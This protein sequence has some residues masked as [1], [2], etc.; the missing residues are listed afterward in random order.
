MR[1]TAFFAW[2][3]AKVGIRSRGKILKTQLQ[4]S[5][6]KNCA[7]VGSAH[8]KR[9][10]VHVRN[11]SARHN[12]KSCQCCRSWKI[13]QNTPLVA[14]FGFDTAENATSEN[15]DIGIPVH[16]YLQ[17]PVPVYPTLRLAS[18]CTW[19]ICN[20]NIWSEWKRN[21]IWSDW[22][23]NNIWSEWKLTKSKHIG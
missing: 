7:N 10:K 20:N 18:C 16:W 15:R 17:P 9:G 8:R 13:H 3:D 22:K 11:T 4:N 14:K 2:S 6:E 12:A 19:G 5:A 21:H 1:K 23:F